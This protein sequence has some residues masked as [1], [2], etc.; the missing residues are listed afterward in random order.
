MGAVK[1]FDLVHARAHAPARVAALA[2]AWVLS[3]CA[4][5][6]ARAPLRVAVLPP[7]RVTDVPAAAVDSAGLVAAA[8]ESRGGIE[9]IDPARTALAVAAVD[10]ACLA[11]PLCQRGVARELGADRTVSIRLAA[12]GT[13]VVV[14]VILAEAGTPALTRQ[15]VIRE[16]SSA[17]VAGAMGRLGAELAEAV[18]PRRRWYRRWWVWT[19]AGVVVGGAAAGVAAAVATRGDGDEPDVII[20]PP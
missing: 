20:T 11:D 5:A 9:V 18:A 1:R 3:G 14:R 15:E 7:E 17:D 4:G 2:L 16:A 12:L 13:T 10:A 6:A 19:I 8:L